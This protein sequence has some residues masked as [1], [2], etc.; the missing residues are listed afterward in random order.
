MANPAPVAAAPV[1]AAPA[2][3]LESPSAEKSSSRSACQ[4]ALV[5]GS[6]YEK[7]YAATKRT[8]VAWRAIGAKATPPDMPPYDEPWRMAAWYR[9]HMERRVPQRLL[10][11]EEAGP[12]AAKP[13]ASTKAAG[14]TAT[15]HPTAPAEAPGASLAL[16]Y[17]A[18]LQR[19][20]QAEA[21]AAQRYFDAVS[22]ADETTREKAAGLKREWGEVAE[23]LRSY[24]KDAAKIQRDSGNLWEAGDVI[25]VISSLHSTI[26]AGVRRL[27][28]QM[29]KLHPDAHQLSGSAQDALW[30]SE[31]DKFFTALKNSR[32]TAATLPAPAAHDVAA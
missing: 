18:T 16:G 15:V 32:F 1:P 24:E 10:D 27:H 22:S 9:S 23:T 3:V 8:L 14:V 13:A 2:L 19:F 11:L 25:E 29:R 4:H 7:T 12:P 26:A 21:V 30:D 31:V 17:G 6:P 20:R 28:R 5:E